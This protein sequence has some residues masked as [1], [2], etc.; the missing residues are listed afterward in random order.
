MGLVWKI[1]FIFKI[2]QV[3]D[4]DS[5]LDY[6]GPAALLLFCY[7]LQYYRRYLAADANS[8]SSEQQFHSLCL[9]SNFVRGQNAKRR[10]ALEHFQEMEGQMKIAQEKKKAHKEE[11]ER[12][13]QAGTREGAWNTRDTIQNS[14]TICALRICCYCSVSD[15]CCTV[16]RR[17]LYKYS[18]E[19]GQ[20][21][22]TV[23]NRTFS[24]CQPEVADLFVREEKSVQ[25]V[26][27]RHC[28]LLQS[29]ST[30]RA[31]GTAAPIRT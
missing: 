29:W 10:Q 15:C 30:G 6:Q 12:R 31:N 11:Q 4:D 13:L 3:T 28:L 20:C 7:L 1:V 21:A 17:R 9:Y 24:C 25:N 23:W 16:G 26:I 27:K 14:C 2:L 8:V 5:C 22:T 18:T 19:H